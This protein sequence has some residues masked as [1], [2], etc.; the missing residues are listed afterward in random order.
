M[1]EEK[2]LEPI[3]GRFEHD[4]EKNRV[5]LPADYI[6]TIRSRNP[7]EPLVLYVTRK[8]GGDI[9]YVAVYDQAEFDEL[10]KKPLNLNR[11]SPHKLGAYHRLSISDHCNALQLGE[12]VILAAS[13][14]GTHLRVWNPRDY[15]Q[16]SWA[17]FEERAKQA[18]TD[19]VP[20]SVSELV[21]LS[22]PYVHSDTP[23]DIPF[24]KEVYQGLTDKRQ[25]KLWNGNLKRILDRNPGTSGHLYIGSGH[26]D[27]F[28]YVTLHDLAGFERA[29]KRVPGMIDCADYERGEFDNDNRIVIPES[30]ADQA[31]L[32]DEVAIVVSPDSDYLQLWN[33]KL[34]RELERKFPETV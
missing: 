30:L 15:L 5:T 8:N 1:S 22:K 23:P 24:I 26:V 28:N 17:R 3:V 29:R 7:N 12:S 19:K 34:R 16:S 6:H 18:R 27:N 20:E 14:D 10:K 13:P 21:I 25:V 2:R 11:F 9:N 4:F 33:A 31:Q 32:K